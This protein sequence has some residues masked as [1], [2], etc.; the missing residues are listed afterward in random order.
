MQDVQTN[1]RNF[2]RVEKLQLSHKIYKRGKLKIMEV[3]AIIHR[4]RRVLN[5]LLLN[6]RSRTKGR[7]L[8]GSNK[9]QHNMDSIHFEPQVRNHFTKTM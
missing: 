1:A 9:I 2:A 7:T 3:P 5:N 4:R 8:T 6:K